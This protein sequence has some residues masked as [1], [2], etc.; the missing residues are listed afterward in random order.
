MEW[1]AL[2]QNAH[3]QCTPKQ[4]TGQG[5]IRKALKESCC[6]PGLK[7]EKAPLRLGEGQALL[8]ESDLS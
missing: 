1:Q 4:Q 8:P 6:D 2:S 7:W 5:S 3:D